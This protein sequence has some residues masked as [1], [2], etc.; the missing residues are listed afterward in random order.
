MDKTAIFRAMAERL[1]Q[2]P[3]HRFIMGFWQQETKCGTVG[4]VIGHCH[5]LIPGLKM[6]N[7]AGNYYPY[8]ETETGV[9]IGLEAISE[10]LD[11]SM[12]NA[13]YI[14][15]EDAYDVPRKENVQARLLQFADHC[16]GTEG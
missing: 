5:D 9:L 1:N 8:F 4:C 11:I 2:V 6:K 13:N 16:E 14:F 15:L 10:A 7:E 12:R 3:N